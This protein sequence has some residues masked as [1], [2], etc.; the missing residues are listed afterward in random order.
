MKKYY[1]VNYIQIINGRGMETNATHIFKTE[2]EA[3]K[4]FDD[5]VNMILTWNDENG[6]RV[7]SHIP[8]NVFGYKNNFND[9]EYVTMSEAVV[10]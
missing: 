10:E 4:Y 7:V 9:Y 6:G 5:S 8:Y 2:A 3:Q 1:V